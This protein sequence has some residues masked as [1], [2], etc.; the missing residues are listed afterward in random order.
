MD[1]AG[2]GVTLTN[3]SKFN[4]LLGKNGCGKSTVLKTL[5]AALDRSVF[6]RVRYISP[7]RGGLLSY[8]PG[9]DQTITGDPNWL[10]TVRRRNQSENF[11]QQSA[12]LFRRLELLILREI[13]R[14]HT[15]P[16]YR[17]RTF[18]EVLAPLNGLLERVRLER[19]VGKAFEIRDRDNENTTVPADLSS[20]ESELISLGIECL[21]FKHEC[22]EE[23]PNVLLI[24]EPDVHLHPDLQNRLAR[25]MLQTFKDTNVTLVLA[26]HSTALLGGLAEDSTASICFMTRRQAELPFQPITDVDRA[27][28]PIFGAHPLSNVFNEAPVLLIEGEDDERVWQQAVRSAEGSVRLYPC[29]VGG[30]THF[31]EFETKVNGVISSVYDNA[32]AFSLRDRD[33]SPE[34]IHDVGNVIRMR[35]SCRAA[36]NL[37]L[38]DDV[39]AY[40]GTDWSTCRTS[41]EAWIANNSDHKFHA[42]MAGFR[43]GG[44]ERKDFDLKEIRNILL[45]LISTKPWE[46]LVGQTIA[47]VAK[48][49]GGVLG[50]DGLTAYLGQKVCKHLLRVETSSEENS[51][52]SPAESQAV[53]VVSES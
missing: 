11:R 28:L 2:G 8:E 40:A 37:M 26:T 44:F 38:S 33:I 50:E 35:L 42:E 49:G 24:D 22:D 25:F 31:A 9:I 12:T 41:V 5:D 39:L 51:D 21:F 14:E 29:V 6:A 15:L 46:V 17:P 47:H 34:A 4:V 23:K 30:N 3:L 18:D 20:G 10:T 13:E 19:D 48:N 52:G 27:I 7:E 36:E 32:R 45:G 43:D 1:L 53:V 16:D